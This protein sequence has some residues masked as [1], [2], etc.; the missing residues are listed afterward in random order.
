V[1]L[2]RLLLAGESADAIAQRVQA[3]RVPGPAW[4]ALA[5]LVEARREAFGQLRGM[6]DAAGIDH[7]G[8][9]TPARI[10]AL[11]DRAVATSP[12]A[13]VAMYSLGDAA[14]L[15]AATG[16]I[17]EWLVAARLF[18]P[19]MDVLDLGC[20]I[21]RIASAL[22]GPARSVLGLD[23]SAGMIREAQLRCSDHPNA[24]FAVS[25]GT[26]LALVPDRSV[27]LA[28]AV[29]SFPYVMQAG[30]DVAEL[31][32]AEA[33]RVLRRRGTLV[34]LNF[35]YRADDTA[36]RDCASEWGARYGLPLTQAG[37]APFRL[38]DG[39]AYV[40]ARTG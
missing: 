9:A 5:R 15:A 22:A 40:F 2:A 34:I 21:G 13:S 39:T 36:D 4:A 6:I 35:S 27:D 23:V 18:A 31:H 25:S 14:T 28:L 20:G 33:A 7:A 1:A 8:A 29:D 30:L 10:A 12:E 16:E 3:A 17:A 32:V 11:F 26:D 38:W 19:G 24:R 37:T